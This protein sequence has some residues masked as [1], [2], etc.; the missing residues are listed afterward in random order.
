MIPWPGV[1]RN[2]RST[3]PSGIIQGAFLALAIAPSSGLPDSLQPPI[4]PGYLISPHSQEGSIEGAD[5]IGRLHSEA[6]APLRD[7][8]SF[9]GSDFS[10]D[11]PP[12]Y[13]ILLGRKN[14]DLANPSR[15]IQPDQ[16]KDT[17]LRFYP[18]N[19]EYFL[20]SGAVSKK[21]PAIKNL[22]LHTLG[23]MPHKQ[24]DTL[25]GSSY[26]ML[27]VESSTGQ[28]LNRL[29]GTI[30]GLRAP[31]DG[32]LELFIGD[33]GEIALRHTPMELKIM[34]LDGDYRITVRR[35]DPNSQ[36]LD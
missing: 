2:P 31:S 27:Q 36:W 19:L 24:W 20:K 12:P 17:W 14:R 21:S 9:E 5:P 23:A 35:N 30:A 8:H 26:P 13:V 11:R 25:P 33:E 15:F 16:Q 34:T 10:E 7:S 4:I 32:A 3:G 29:D 18:R 28:L 1:H 22:V 6:D